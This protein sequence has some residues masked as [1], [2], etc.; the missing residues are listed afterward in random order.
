MFEI[1]TVLIVYSRTELNDRLLSKLLS[2]TLLVLF[3][4]FCYTEGM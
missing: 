1:L 4:T 3:D 2:I